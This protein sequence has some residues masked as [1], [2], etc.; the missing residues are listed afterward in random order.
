MNSGPALQASR[1][2]F[3]DVIRH[4]RIGTRQPIEDV[5]EWH[6]GGIATGF[7]A[8]ASRLDSY[9]SPVL[10]FVA[11]DSFMTRKIMNSKTVHA[12]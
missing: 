11:L 3:R 5:V 6:L 9:C 7:A 4:A 10:D 12:G 8:E 1:R 2:N